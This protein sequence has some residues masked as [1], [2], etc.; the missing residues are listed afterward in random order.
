MMFQKPA[1]FLFSGKEAP[2]V[3][4]PSNEVILNQRAPQKQ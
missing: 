1:L 4:D 2:N 3:V